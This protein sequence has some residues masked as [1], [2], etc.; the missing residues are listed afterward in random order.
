MSK[1]Y[2]WAKAYE[3][4]IQDDMRVYY[5]DD[6]FICYEITQNYNQ[7]YNFAIDYGYNDCGEGEVKLDD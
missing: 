5:E 6:E 7:S 3:Q 4:L 2:Y 1:M